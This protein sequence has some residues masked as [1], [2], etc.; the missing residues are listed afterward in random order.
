MKI[1]SEEGLGWQNAEGR[2]A[3]G[4]ERKDFSMT[5][6]LVHCACSDISTRKRHQEPGDDDT[7]YPYSLRDIK[8]QVRCE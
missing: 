2:E 6:W 7:E 1:G 5:C 3:Q 4:K 8:C